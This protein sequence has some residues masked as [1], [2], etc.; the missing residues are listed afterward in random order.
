[1]KL[2]S[3]Y[4]LKQRLHALLATA[5]PSVPGTLVRAAGPTARIEAFADR[6]DA[7]HTRRPAS[8]HVAL[9]VS[10]GRNARD[11]RLGARVQVAGPAARTIAERIHREARGESDVRIVPR[12]RRRAPTPAWFRKRHRPLE[13]GLSIG[14]FAITAG[15]LGAIV[16]DPDACYGLSNN[17]V[18]ADVNRAAP[19]DPIVQPGPLDVRSGRK[20]SPTTLV[21]VLD[22]FVPIS[23]QRSNVVDCGVAELL[24]GVEYYAGWTEAI[25]GVVKGVAPVTVD[26]LGRPVSKAGRTTGVTRGSITQVH[27]DRLKVDMGDEGRPA[28]ALFSDQIEVEGE[29]RAFSDGGDSGSLIVGADGVARALL[30]AGGEEEETGRDLTYANALTTVLQKLGVDL[31]A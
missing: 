7:V 11:F 3:V 14:H 24:P 6:L 1:M 28:I 31:V 23:F 20:V 21:G 30:F 5:A 2:D 17:H 4:D 22:R 19:G 16:E 29:R 18:L 26:D 9:G 10:A 12:V 13:A 15:T 8:V 27:V 25:P